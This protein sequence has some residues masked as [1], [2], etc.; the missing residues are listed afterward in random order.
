[1]DAKI[2]SL[3]KLFGHPKAQQPG[4]SPGSL[5]HTGSEALPPLK[6]D[7]ITFDES[8]VIEKPDADLESCLKFRDVSTSW[9]NVTGVHDTAVIEQLGTGFNVHPLILE[10]IVN[11][12]QR[13]K[14]EEYDECMFF[15]LRMYMWDEEK[16]EIKSENISI[17]LGK[18]F[19][20]SFQE[21]EGDVFDPI[22]KRIRDTKKRIRLRGTDYL[23]YALIDAL[24]DHYFVIL[25]RL[26]E[27]IENL[28]EKIYENPKLENRE[29]LAQIKEEVLVIQRS[30]LPLR[31]VFLEI[32]N[33]DT[34]FIHEETTLYFR[35]V[36]DHVIQVIEHIDVIRIKL[37]EINE[38]YISILSH[39]TNEVMKVL[40]VVATIFIPLSFVAGIY[41]T[42]FKYL[43]E[44]GWEGSYF[45]MLGA[46]AALGIIMYSYFKKRKWV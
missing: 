19:V 41:G 21:T 4:L 23:A 20:L 24:I 31:Q 17:V 37:T 16:N 42:N 36:Y 12:T 26:G 35:D 7:V 30:I 22:R 34:P 10:D 9:I 25:D 1:M 45:V 40:A 28:E 29:E 8:G 3:L 15:V 14:M 6:M 2:I 39:K 18:S 11:T 46:M 13:P 43:P 5:I 32:P 33:M 27:R 44:L 38:F